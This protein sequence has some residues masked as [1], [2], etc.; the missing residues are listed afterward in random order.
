MNLKRAIIAAFVLGL[1]VM[2]PMGVF[3]DCAPS[4][5]ECQEREAATG[6]TD[7]TEETDGTADADEEVTQWTQDE[8]DTADQDRKRTY[9]AGAGATT[10]DPKCGLYNSEGNCF[11]RN[12]LERSVDLNNNCDLDENLGEDCRYELTK[13]EDACAN[14]DD[15][16]DILKCERQEGGGWEVTN[17]TGVFDSEFYSVHNNETGLGLEGRGNR[18]A[19][20]E[21]GPATTTTVVM[22]AIN[23]L[24]SMVSLLA[25]AVFIIGIFFLITANGEENQIQKGKDAIKYSILGIVFTLLSYTIVVFIQSIFS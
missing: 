4:D 16:H 11:Y 6:E 19:N 18:F 3:A 9:C 23:F 25:L 8:W 13:R 22:A 17:S 2:S 7:G 1:M 14:D 5:T 21:G 12:S 20:P 15:C 24:A 10:E